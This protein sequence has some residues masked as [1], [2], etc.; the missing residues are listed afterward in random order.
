MRDRGRE[1]TRSLEDIVLMGCWM[2]P[3]LLLS[4]THLNCMCRAFSFVWNGAETEEEGY[5]CNTVS[6]CVHQ[7]PCLFSL[8]R[9]SLDV[10][11]R[12]VKIKISLPDK[13]VR[14]KTFCFISVMRLRTLNRSVSHSVLT[15]QL[16]AKEER[17]S[18]H[19]STVLLSRLH[20]KMEINE[21]KVK[22]S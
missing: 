4:Q 11:L 19:M 12:G 22:C 14:S 2:G 18:L 13:W 15:W 20:S 6:T 8:L 17:K 5:K 3:L 1:L 21:S 16:K 9:I 10:V 7:H